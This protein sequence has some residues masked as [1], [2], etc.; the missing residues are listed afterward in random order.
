[1]TLPDPLALHLLST[2]TG[3][4][5]RAS[6]PTTPPTADLLDALAE[7]FGPATDAPA[8]QAVLARAALALAA[9]DPATGAA[10]E[11][12]SERTTQESYPILETIALIST[13]TAALA[14]LQTELSIERTPA[15]KWKVKLHKKPASDA[16][17]KGLAQAI[18]RA[19]GGTD[20]KAPPQ[21]PK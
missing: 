12:L 3:P 6:P 14:I 15:G 2:I 9:A 11:A 10:I 13:V 16:L 1:M 4:R 17:L 21:L 5:L 20:G 7:T 8:T 18:M 19:L